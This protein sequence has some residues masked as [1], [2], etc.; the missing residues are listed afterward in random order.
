[1]VLQ[2]HFIQ[3]W[4]PLHLP[5]LVDCRFPLNEGDLTRIQDGFILELR[6]IRNVHVVGLLGTRRGRST[7]DWLR[8]L[9]RRRLCLDSSWWQCCL[10]RGGRWRTCFVGQHSAD[11]LLGI[12]VT[13]HLFLGNSGQLFGLGNSRRTSL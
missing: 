5:E 1:M 13:N 3:L 9:E 8:R 2:K 6:R 4:F 11:F 12:V 10:D 7:F